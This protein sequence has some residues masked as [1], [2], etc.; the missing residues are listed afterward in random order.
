MNT[1]IRRASRFKVGQVLW[2]GVAVDDPPT[3]SKRIEDTELVPVVLDLV[4][5]QDIDGYEGDGATVESAA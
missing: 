4:T 2:V 5:G 3:A 1:S